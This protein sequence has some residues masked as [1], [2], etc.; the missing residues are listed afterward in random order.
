M[1]RNG[2][3]RDPYCETGVNAMNNSSL[4]SANKSTHVKIVAVALVAGIAVIGVGLA[5]KHDLGTDVLMTPG[6]KLE[7]NGPVIRAGKPTMITSGGDTV[8]R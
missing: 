4:L 5:A 2:E 8:I 3:L 1:N 7:A 6:G